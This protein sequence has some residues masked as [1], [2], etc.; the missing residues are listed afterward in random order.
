MS[1]VRPVLMWV[2]ADWV[3]AGMKGLPGTDVEI[4]PLD[5]GG[6]PPPNVSEVE[7][8]VPSF[9]PTPASGEVMRYMKRLRVVQGHG[10]REFPGPDEGRWRMPAAWSLARSYLSPGGRPSS[11]E[12]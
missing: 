5:G 3:A 10:R 9:F 11:T 2:P 7:F 1:T 12:A 4:V 6:P 8:Y